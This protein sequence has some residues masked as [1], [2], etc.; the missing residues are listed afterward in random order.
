[1]REDNYADTSV[2]EEGRRGGRCPGTPLLGE[3]LGET[4][5]STSLMGEEVE[6]LG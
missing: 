1:M 3:D 2:S 4:G 6:E 5:G